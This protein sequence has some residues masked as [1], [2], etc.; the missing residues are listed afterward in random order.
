MTRTD[1]AVRSNAFLALVPGLLMTLYGWMVPYLPSGGGF[2]AA[3]MHIFNFTLQ[4]GGPALILAA[5]LCWLGKPAGLWLDA[6]GSV[7]CGGI[8]MLIGAYWIVVD[9]DLNDFIIGLFGLLVFRSGRRQLTELL[10]RGESAPDALPSPPAPPPPPSDEIAHAPQITQATDPPPDGY[11]AA[12]GR[13]A[14][15]RREARA[16]QDTPDDA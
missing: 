15:E 10:Q 14:K 9:H 5:L 2:H 1:D 16:R 6:I 7:T 8:L 3:T 13:A 12:L 11:L 4:F